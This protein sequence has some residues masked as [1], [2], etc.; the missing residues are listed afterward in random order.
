M[1]RM[2]TRTL[3]TWLL[4]LAAPGALAADAAPPAAPPGTGSEEVAPPPGSP[5]DQKLWSD[6]T[7]AGRR[8]IVERYAANKM[9]WAARQGRHDERV[10]ALAQQ[11]DGPGAKRA[12]E[13]SPRLR[14]A[15]VENYGILTRPWPVDPT[16]GC[17]YELLNL[18]GV[19]RS[20]EA[21]RKASQLRVVR[22]ETEECLEKATAA[23]RVMAASNEKLKAAMAEA[24]ALL[25]PAPAATPAA[26]ASAAPTST[27][28]K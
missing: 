28:A 6:A 23:I 17:G 3:V 1:R 19:M 5:A 16:R 9:Q 14:T 21:P 22:E 15:L 25:G 26:S 18:E 10:A 7:E 11:A 4:T 8:I 20:A 2:N 27:A 24:E 12:Q 13:L